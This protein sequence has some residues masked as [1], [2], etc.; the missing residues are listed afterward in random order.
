[1]TGTTKALMTPLELTV[2]R[3]THGYSQTKL[4]KAL[5]MARESVNRYESGAR[6]VPP[7]M[8]KR[9]ADIVA[10]KPAGINGIT[11]VCSAIMGHF[12]HLK[13]YTVA[14]YGGRKHFLFDGEHPRFMM[15]DGVHY[16]VHNRGFTFVQ[17]GPLPDGKWPVSILTDPEYLRR[18]ERHRAAGSPPKH[19]HPAMQFPSRIPVGMS[20]AEAER[21]KQDAIAAAGASVEP[22]ITET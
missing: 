13:L 15:S 17:R 22:A 8:A 12:P 5:G 10:D 4:A 1:M 9:L 2:W 3:K 16:D 18:V 19:E 11:E 21:M 14:H 20:V 7:D 6:T